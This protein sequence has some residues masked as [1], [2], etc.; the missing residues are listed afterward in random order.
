MDVNLQ[1][2]KFAFAYVKM[3]VEAVIVFRG[4]YVE[5]VHE[6][7][8]AMQKHLKL[9]TERLTKSWMRHSRDTLRNYLV[10]DVQDP[11]INVQSILTRHFLI[12]QLFGELFETLMEHELRFALVVN[13]L[14]GLLKKPVRPQ[15]LLSVLDA[16]LIG[17][18]NAEGLKVP[19]YISQTFAALAMPNYMCDLFCWSPVETTGL[20]IP[21][22]LLSTF[23]TIWREVLAGKQ[24]RR[25]SVLEP[26]CGSANDYRFLD[27]FGIARLLDYMGFD[28]CETN[29]ANARGMFPG[30]QFKVGNVLEIDA[31]DGAYDYCFIHDLFE[32][33]SIEALEAA[34]AEICRVTQ[35]GICAGFFNMHDGDAHIVKAVG[36]YHW[37]T[38]SVAKT[39]ALFER[40][41]SA[42]E[43]DHIDALLRS[44]FGCADTHNKGAWT[45]IIAR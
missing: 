15:Q 34:I 32:H 20:S 8:T 37:N 45:F 36:D 42:V 2:Q 16:L 40:H 7:P 12:E 23:E 21:E 26:A 18:D 17:E 24:P 33:L 28:L 1:A 4:T 38:L 19:P 11:R 35:K 9:E 14:L 29:I 27:A 6:A 10:Q 5:T 43:V 31:A 44:R 25:I 39:K 13:W 41:C 3:L 30:V 22:Y